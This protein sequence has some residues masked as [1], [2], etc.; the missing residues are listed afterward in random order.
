MK[1][2]KKIA[3][4]PMMDW[5][6]SPTTQLTDQELASDRIVSRTCVAPALT[7]RRAQ[8]GDNQY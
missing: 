1:N 5:T 3:I 4:A 7:T 8:T 6:E 2:K